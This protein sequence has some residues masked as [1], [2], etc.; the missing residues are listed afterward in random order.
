MT[1]RR[2]LAALALTALAGIAAGPAFAQD[3]AA[4]PP[5]GA[6]PRVDKQPVTAREFIVATAHPLAT[7][8]GWFILAQG[9]TAVDAAIAVQLVLGLVEPQ[10]SGL[11]GGAFMLVHDARTA[12][13]T[14]LDGRESAPAAARPDRFLG[15]D[16]TPMGFRDAVIG[17]RS[18]GVP[19]TVALLAEA[20]RRHGRLAWEELFAPAIALAEGGFPVSPRLSAALAREGKMRQPRAQA[21]FFAPDG[22]PPAVG[23]RLANPAYGATLRALA[24]QGPQPFYRG[25]IARDIVDTVTTAPVA[26]GDLALADLARYRVVVR[27]PVCGGYRGYRVC[28]APPPSSGGLAVAAILGILERRGFATLALDSTAAAHVFAE[29]G[30]LAYADRAFVAD[31]AFV[32]APSWLL[33]PDYLARRAAEIADDRSLGTA[34]PGVPPP[35]PAARKA[36]A[37]DTPALELPATSH[38]SIV[39]RD[40]SAVAM[41]ASIEDAFGSRLLTASGFL[42]NNELTDFAFVPVVDGK[43]VAN[44]VEAGKRPRSAMA[45]TIVYDPQGRVFMVVGS[46][47]GPSIINYVARTIVGVI[48]GR[49][50]PQAAA[51]LPFVGSRNGPTEVEAGT[52]AA[53]LAPGLRALGHAVTVGPHPS[54]TQAIVR[55]DG[56]WIGGADPRR[57]GT[58][59]GE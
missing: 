2:L 16:G 33:D 27:D 38:F 30:R 13:L 48:D 41:T 26:P 24:A 25:A 44:R 29:A 53:A 57:D 3:V 20:H 4:A 1:L 58:V 22:A 54:G 46:A 32:P 14:V 39:D 17:G 23:A 9:G 8:A 18:V 56:G 34:K 15:R 45:P 12:R 11:G 47:G 7:E 6:T 59:R 43:P 42:L 5:E 35:T 10:S 21:Y 31:P 49:L 37:A 51:A 52:A 36:A 19:G 28:G 40:G 50:D 55:T